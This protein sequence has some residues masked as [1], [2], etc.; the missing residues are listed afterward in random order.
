MYSFQAKFYDRFAGTQSSARVEVQPAVLEIFLENGKKMEWILADLRSAD[1]H[2]GQVIL[3]RGEQQFLEIN[4]PQF[5][6]VFERRMQASH[7][8]RKRGFLDRVGVAGCLVSLALAIGL[9]V[10]FFFWGVPW[11]ATR[12]ADQVSPET[13][14]KIGDAMVAPII[15]KMPLDSTKTRLAQQF[16][17]AL[18]FGGP[19]KFRVSVVRMSDMNAFAA[20][21]GRIVVFDSIIGMMDRPEELAA[22]FGHEA[23]HVLLRH[24]TRSVFR[25][26]ANSMTLALVVGDLGGVAGLAAEH[27]N[28]LWGLSY[29]RDLE[30]EADENSFK[31]ISAAGVPP[32]GMVSLLEKMQH[33]LQKSGIAEGK[34]FFNTHPSTAERIEL[35][36]QKIKNLNDAPTAVRPELEE[37]FKK[38]KG[39]KI[40][41]GGNW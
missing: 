22:L 13:E 32:S 30:I 20:P 14:Q 16:F 35:V 19:Y 23:S 28:Q 18:N 5:R 9:V 15:E 26:L 7:L 11:L 4:D 6:Q 24:S 27:A 41:A 38:L 8:F 29:S 33:N 1:D 40:V 12:A 36:Q 25:D 2:D 37:I 17:D 34:S 3:Q 21:G 31:L 39:E 10:A